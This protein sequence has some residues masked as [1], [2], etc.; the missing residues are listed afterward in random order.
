MF[1]ARTVLCALILV[2]VLPAF[3]GDDAHAEPGL[4]PDEQVAQMESTCAD[5]A[6]ARAARH[7]EIPLFERLGGEERIHALTKEI[8]RL[9]LE[10]EQVKPFFAGLDHD[11]VAARVAQFL[12]TGS[13]GPAVYNG[14]ALADSHRHMKLV[15]GD[16]MNAGGDVIQAMQNLEFGQ[17]EIDEV[18][19]SLVGLRDQ[20]VLSA[21]P[22]AHDHGDHDGHDH[23]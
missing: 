7:A 4:T 21:A 14:P 15:N 11:R 2:A 12:I 10:N 16:F 13:G 5:S 22:H 19:C 1:H 23:E 17:N 9:H 3:A 18:V 8:V 6:E 20:V